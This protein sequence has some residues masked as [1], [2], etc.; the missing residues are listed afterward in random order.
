MQSGFLRVRF[1]LSAGRI[2][3]PVLS[4][5]RLL[6]LTGIALGTVGSGHLQA[7]SSPVAT[8]TTLTS[9]VA[10]TVTGTRAAFVVHV[11]PNGGDANAS[12][13]V[14][15]M[16][17]TRDIGSAVLNAD[18]EA[19]LTVSGLL[20]GDHAV[21]AVYPGTD[22][23]ASSVSAETQVVAEATSTVP[24][25]TATASP[26]ALKVPQGTTATTT[27]TLTPVNG[28][29]NYVSLSCSGLPADTA[30]TFL[31]VNVSVSGTK[32]TTSVLS[33]ETYGPTSSNGMVRQ[34]ST[35]VYALAFPG[36]LA[37]FGL[38]MRR[39]SAAWKNAGL[40]LLAFA[41]CSLSIGLMSGCSQRYHYL[42][43]SPVPS[44]GTAYG[45]FSFT[46][47]AQATSG[48]VITTQLI[49]NVVVTVTA[50]TS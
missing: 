12:G 13:V 37:I 35:M 3:S 39:G 2:V 20:P 19:T 4:I 15:L 16:D 1:H 17:G 42:N 47:E 43:K 21:H 32:A 40:M 28:F 45:P 14:T 9:S 50:P 48:V 38:G 27:I 36:I 30:C 11:S 26:T 23:L 18:G 34:R 8:E 25:F 24:T 6:S 33:I 49:Q 44:P 31:P 7:Q 10:H 5:C 29:S 41:G 46:I 22:A